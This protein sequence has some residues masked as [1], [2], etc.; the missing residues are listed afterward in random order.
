MN[1]D[2]ME[3]LGRELEVTP[4]RPEAY[5]RSRA[6]LRA[7]IAESASQL[8][9]TAETR[10]ASVTAVDAMRG[11]GSSRVGHRGFGRWGTRGK[12]GLGAGLGAVAAGAALVL[13]VTASPPASSPG[14]A[15]KVSA[16]PA[17]A[18]PVVES[19]LISLAAYITASSGPVSG[20]ST[21][22][23]RAQTVGGRRPDVSYNLYTDSGEFYGGGDKKSL[24]L[25]ISRHENEASGITGREVAA[26]R[27]AVK[28]D[29]DTARKRMVNAAPNDFGVGL[30]AA[31]R[32]K[33]WDKALARDGAIW[34]AKGSPLRKH[35]PTGKRLEA[36]IGNRIWDNGVDAMTAG[37]GDPQVRAGV[38]R[39]LSTVSAVTVKKSTTGGQDT[40]TLTAGSAL[41]SGGSPQVLTV[42]AKTGMPV[43][44]AVK[45][46]DGAPASVSTFKVSRLTLADAKVGKY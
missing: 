44:S 24:A 33:I 19:P 12:V 27:Y 4:W 38:L 37:G 35:P 16:G 9:S 28:G 15:G 1:V 13:V 21:L 22:V 36:L 23:I 3:L 18:A 30:S 5:E 32:Q 31:E 42:D 2:E 11:K 45:A 7:A 10:L 40:L 34:K 46:G 26:A 17:S 29:L 43:K 14:T 41:F 39:L 20:D 8:G 25:A 6:V